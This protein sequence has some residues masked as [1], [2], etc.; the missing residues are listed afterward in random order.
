MSV[1]RVVTIVPG[2][3]PPGQLQLVTTDTNS[4]S[5]GVDSC[6]VN[7]NA[8]EFLGRAQ[9]CVK[10]SGVGMTEENLSLLFQEGGC[11]MPWDLALRLD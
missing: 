2:G 3:D 4:I 10:D 9:I 7:F 11:A 5:S 6:T 8:L 1:C